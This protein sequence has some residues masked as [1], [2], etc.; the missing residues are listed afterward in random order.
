M[1]CVTEET[2]RKG[3][4]TLFI[5]TF[6]QKGAGNSLHVH[7]HIKTALFKKETRKCL[8]IPGAF[9]ISLTCG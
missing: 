3:Y 4:T 1:G 2:N 9:F 8:K 6:L 7:R 5:F